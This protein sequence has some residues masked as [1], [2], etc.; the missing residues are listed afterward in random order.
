VK[1]FLY[2]I[3]P[4][5]HYNYLRK[6]NEAGEQAVRKSKWLTE[7][8]SEIMRA[9]GISADRAGRLRPVPIVVTNQG[10][11]FGLDASGARIIDFHFLRLYFS[12]N[13]YVAGMAL[14]FSDRQAVDQVEILY[15]SE[16]EA[17]DNFEKTMANPPPLQR[18]IRAAEWKEN[19][20]PLSSGETMIVENCLVGE[21]IADE[22]NRLAATLNRI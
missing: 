16:A 13:E 11:G 18:Y 1:C 3:E 15:G 14:K 7:N 12:D 9:V 10:A 8:P 17:A 20:F 5:E 19:R 22:A 6:L 21:S 2:P 4:S